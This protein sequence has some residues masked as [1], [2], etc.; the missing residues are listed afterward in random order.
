VRAN[1]LIHR[2]L[3]R[4]RRIIQRRYQRITGETLPVATPVLD[5][6]SGEVHFANAESDGEVVRRV[7]P[8]TSLAL[9]TKR[10][11]RS[12]VSPDDEECDPIC[13]ICFAPLEDGDRIGA[14][15]CSHIFHVVCLKQWS[16]RRNVC[17]LCQ[18]P[19]AATPIYAMTREK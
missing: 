15:S 4:R 10:Y 17:P 11:K 8:P 13:T 3:R 9:R 19:E 1:L 7:Q 6:N 12:D 18:E 16:R 2:N 14:L 5:A